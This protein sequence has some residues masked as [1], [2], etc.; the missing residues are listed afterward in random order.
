[1]NDY[2]AILR[3]VEPHTEAHPAA[4]DASREDTTVFDL[5]MAGRRQ[6]WPLVISLVLGLGAG[7][8]FYATSPKEYFAAA[9]VLV[10]DRVRNL[11][12]EISSNQPLV[13][14]DTALLNEIQV[15]K[16]QQM[17]ERVVRA[18]RLYENEGFLSPRPS[19]AARVVSG[20]KD[21]LR[22]LLPVSF[23]AASGP[24]A[25]ADGD[26][27]TRLIRQTAAMLQDRIRISR[28]GR[29]FS[30]SIGLLDQDPAVSAMVA[31]AYAEAYLADQSTA[32]RAASKRTAKW[33]QQ[34]LDE[35][36]QRA[37]KAARAAAEFKLRNG[38][39]DVQG[40]R[41]LQHRVD[42]LNDL[43]QAISKRY[44]QT[45]VEG[46]F[47]VTNGRILT[48]AMVPDRAAA[49]KLA[50]VLGIFGLIGLLGGLMVA[51]MRERSEVYFRTG[52]DVT[53][54]TGLAFLGY[55]PV[56]RRNRLRMPSVAEVDRTA[57][58]ANPTFISVRKHAAGTD[59]AVKSGAGSRSDGRAAL[60][61]P[62]TAREA[63]EFMMALSDPNSY[64]METLRNVHTTFE[65]KTVG[66]AG[67][68]I[69]ITSALPGE[70]TT[71]LA[72][73]Y[74]NMLSKFGARTLLVDA[75]VH[76]PSL[77]NTLGCTDLP[78]IVQ[79]I[80]G[81]APLR[82]A[83]RRLPTTGLD[84]LPCPILHGQE[85]P[86]D[87]FFRAGSA[88]IF[89][90]MRQYYDY[91]ILDLPALSTAVDTKAILKSIDSL[92]LVEEWGGVPRELVKRLLA[93]EPEIARKTL[94][95]V[96]NKAK[97]AKLSRYG[98]TLRSGMH[99][100]NPGRKRWIMR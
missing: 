54:H 98:E 82:E 21:R 33:M 67:G 56:F 8:L 24:A 86:N 19:L 35:I 77:S 58:E 43:Y 25:P 17:A 66:A 99:F 80:E 65:L 96:L 53:H 40:L 31:N 73:N 42:S 26:T 44:E 18:T 22:A 64:Y 72:A 59:P 46:T 74:A 95:I 83:L 84:F 90:A 23:G 60:R 71:T 13:R 88:K 4:Q 9:T 20:L 14:N 69:A 32:N 85:Y 61:V 48:Y 38:A 78:G 1:M 81:T 45:I 39:S 10:E 2:Q 63:P 30:V 3:E 57:R 50:Q 79:V 15:L 70:G 68:V 76:R 28:L 62:D 16:S 89:T 6:M 51:V 27:Q 94:G 92:V 37:D 49:P 97:L 52:E 12:Q 34:R 55:L 93:R 29:S 41:E 75:N 11:S 36:R 87:I 47:P 100:F 91:V 7:V 5:L